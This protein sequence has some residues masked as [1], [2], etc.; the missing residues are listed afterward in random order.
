[1]RKRVALAHMPAY[2]PGTLLMDEP[3]GALGAQ[4]E[5]VMQHELLRILERTRKTAVFVTRDIGEAFALAD[6]MVVFSERPG[7]VAAVHAIDRS[8]PRDVFRMRFQSRC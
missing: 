8:R 1:M 6:R 5:L 2:D 3:L 4:P 7:R